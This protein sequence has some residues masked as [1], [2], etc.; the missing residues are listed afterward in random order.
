MWIG[1]AGNILND[2]AGFNWGGGE[3]RF[4]NTAAAFDESF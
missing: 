3:E 4:G 2:Y 1:V